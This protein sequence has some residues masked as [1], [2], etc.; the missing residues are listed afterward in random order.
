MA[1]GNE[2]CEYGRWKATDAKPFYKIPLH[3]GNAFG[4][5]DKKADREDTFFP[6][7]LGRGYNPQGNQDQ[8]FNQGL[9]NTQAFN[10]YITQPNQVYAPM[11]LS[12]IGRHWS[13]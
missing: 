7:P 6:N 4:G 5:V 10:E 3:Y 13:P 9:P 11:A 2:G 1:I 8:L 12:P